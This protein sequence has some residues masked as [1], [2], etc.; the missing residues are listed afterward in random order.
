VSDT[1]EEQADE[2]DET[3]GV[4]EWGAGVAWL[5]HRA[6]CRSRACGAV[7]DDEFPVLQGAGGSAVRESSSSVK[8]RS[9]LGV[10]PL[11]TVTNLAGAMVMTTR[12]LVSAS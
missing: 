9:S 11:S 10:M 7:F 5:R 6:G 1:G 8:R 12:A 2:L 3:P 4:E